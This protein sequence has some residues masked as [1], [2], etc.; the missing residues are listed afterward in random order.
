MCV[1]GEDSMAGTAG[2]GA[3]DAE[4]GDLAVMEVAQ[5]LA[6][7]KAQRTQLAQAFCEIKYNKYIYTYVCGN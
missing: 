5:R 2:P 7:E 1:A 4:Y 3:V 6:N